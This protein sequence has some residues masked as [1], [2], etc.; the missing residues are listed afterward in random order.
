MQEAYK[1][2]GDWIFNYIISHPKKY[3]VAAQILRR[4]K[5]RKLYRIVGHPVRLMRSSFSQK[6]IEDEIRQQDLGTIESSRQSTWKEDIG[7]ILSTIVRMSFF[8]T[9]S[10]A[11]L[12][13]LRCIN[14]FV[15]DLIYF[16][17]CSIMEERRKEM[18]RRCT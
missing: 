12:D 3:E 15:L 4:I 13:V 9:K 16:Y 8:P 11:V 2:L 7:V 10:E 17:Q 1:G 18:A 5:S 6:E 14:Y